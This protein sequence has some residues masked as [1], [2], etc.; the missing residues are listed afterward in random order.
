[1]MS[2]TLLQPAVVLKTGSVTAQGLATSVQSQMN[3]ALTRFLPGAYLQYVK[4]ALVDG[5]LQFTWSN[6]RIL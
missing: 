2:D 3:L 5:K 6:P 4:V 1:M